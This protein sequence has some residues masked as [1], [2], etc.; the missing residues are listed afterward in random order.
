MKYEGVGFFRP[1]LFLIG[2]L[3]LALAFGAESLSEM[4]INFA[5]G[6]GLCRSIRF[7][8]DLDQ[9]WCCCIHRG[10]Y[11]LDHASETKQNKGISGTENRPYA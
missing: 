6:N 10:R 4:D 5:V 1:K 9:Y 3:L 8:L 11:S 2:L 7:S